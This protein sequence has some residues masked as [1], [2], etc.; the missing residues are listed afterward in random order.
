MYFLGSGNGSEKLSNLRQLLFIGFPGKSQV[1]DMG[2]RLSDEGVSQVLPGFS[3]SHR[4]LIGNKLLLGRITDR[5]L[6][7]GCLLEA[8]MLTYCAPP[9]SSSY[10]LTFL[11]KTEASS[12][13]PAKAP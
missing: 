9:H 12:W 3:S 8:N 1:S 11:L 2:L 6:N 4:R 7:R 5:A 13:L 10:I